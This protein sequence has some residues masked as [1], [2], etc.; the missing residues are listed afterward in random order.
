MF[1]DGLPSILPHGRQGVAQFIDPIG[2]GDDLDG[3]GPSLASGRLRV[4]AGQQHRQIGPAPADFLRQLNAIHASG[5]H[6]VREDDINRAPI[7]EGAERGLGARDASRVVPELSDHLDGQRGN[8]I[9]VLDHQ[10]LRGIAL[11][12]VGGGA[13]SIL[14]YTPGSSAYAARNKL[15]SGSS[16]RRALDPD[17]SAGCLREPMSLSEPQ[18]GAAADFLGR[19]EGFE[20]V[21]QGIGGHAYP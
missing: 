20:G 19:E 21:I 16:P 3:L 8:L 14:E 12:V 9:I 17:R 6:H 2:F 10:Y 15:T 5:H 7:G 11:S 1:S 4:A 13:A 18:P